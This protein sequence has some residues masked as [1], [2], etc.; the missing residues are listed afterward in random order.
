MFIEKRPVGADHP[1]Y[2]IAEISANH[3]GEIQNAIKLIKIA[4]ESGASAVKLQTYTPETITL[5]CATD[6]FRIQ[7]G[8][9]KGQTLYDL[10]QS[11]HMPWEWQTELFSYARSIGITIFSSAF[12]PTSV[13]FLESLKCPAYKIASFEAIDLPLI[14][15]AASTGKPL[16][17]STGL[18]NKDEI[19]EAI[20]TAY[21][22]GCKELAILHCVSGYPANPSDCNLRTIQDMR[23][24]FDVQVG[25]SDHTIN[26]N[27]A[28]AA[29]S[30]GATIIEKHITLDRTGGGPD[31]SFS[32]EPKDLSSLCAGLYEVWTALGTT[33]YSIKQSEK[34]NLKFRRSLYFVKDLKKGQ[35]IDSNCVRSIR[36]GYGLAP[37]NLK[38]ILGKKVTVD[39][40]RGTPCAWELIND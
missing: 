6:D 37:K 26:N 31:D 16:I 24:S 20:E 9:W 38:K 2:V 17:I 8:L 19:A 5:D 34:E 36:P 25:L 30:L 7:E 22:A 4:K 14:Q 29:V 28:I 32:L 39:V 18:A 35:I 15:Y 3:N 11:A 27:A 21:T 33:N 40:F 12:D 23:Q 13:D 10:Y 1:P